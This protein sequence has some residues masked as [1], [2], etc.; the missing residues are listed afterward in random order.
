M[1]VIDHAPSRAPEL[2]GDND[3]FSERGR[4]LRMVDSLAWR[5]GWHRMGFDEKQVWCTFVIEPR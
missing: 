4:G 1:M 3:L 2:P 5:W